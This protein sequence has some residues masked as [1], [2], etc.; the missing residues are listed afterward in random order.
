MSSEFEDLTDDEVRRRVNEGDRI[1]SQI[2]NRYAKLEIKRSLIDGTLSETAGELYDH[3]RGHVSA[4]KCSMEI[5]G[6]YPC[7]IRVSYAGHELFSLKHTEL[8]DLA[9]CV[10]R[11]KVIA[12][13]K[14]GKDAEEV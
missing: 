14:L 12:R 11:A 6:P 1:T 8:A 3:A 7:W 10:E 4:G 9:H 13:R 5:W 2:A